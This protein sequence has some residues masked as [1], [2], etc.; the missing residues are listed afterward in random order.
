[1]VRRNPAKKEIMTQQYI[2]FKVVTAWPEDREYDGE[3]KPGYAVK[4]EDG[5]ISWSPK[6]VFEKAYVPIDPNYNVT[7]RT[8][9]DDC[10]KQAGHQQKTAK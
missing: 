10:R 5:Y 6:E 3:I 8:T 4:Y 9:A 2:G 7:V 1:V